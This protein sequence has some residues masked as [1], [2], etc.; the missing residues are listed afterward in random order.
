MATITLPNA[1][2]V[3]LKTMLRDKVSTL[4]L[5]AV[6]DPTRDTPLASVDEARKAELLAL[7]AR[8]N[9]DVASLQGASVADD[10]ADVREI[11]S[12]IPP[13]AAP[14]MDAAQA[15]VDEALKLW[16]DMDVDG[17][18]AK[19][20]DIATRAHT[21]Q[22]V[23]VQVPVALTGNV[24]PV[25]R[26]AKPAVTQAKRVG[27]I[28]ARDIL[29]SKCPEELGGISMAT[30]DCATAPA[31]DP[32]YVWPKDSGAMIAKLFKRHQAV[33]LVG[34]A[35]TGKTTFAQQ[36]AAHTHR[37]YI[38]VSCHAQTDAPTLTGMQAP[39][40]GGGTEWRDGQLTA[41]I[42][43]AG[44]II[45]I[46]EPFTARP[47]VL[48]MLHALLDSRTLH[49]DE[50]G[51]VVPVADG[52]LFILADNTNGTGDVSGQYVACN[53]VSRAL[54]SRVAY[55]SQVD[56]LA[57]AAEARVIVKR[58]G[59]NDAVARLLTEYADATRVQA[60]KG[61]IPHG[62]GMREL[63]SWAESI[64]DGVPS[65]QAAQGAFLN[66]CPPEQAEHFRQL[67]LT[68]CSDQMVRDALT[69]KATNTRAATGFSVVDEEE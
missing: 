18:K 59:C 47:G 31:I 20:A 38:R 32:F 9:I 65:M 25:I 6:S 67:L 66:T 10:A 50:T 63:V 36:L 17:F 57:P 5:Q 37:P 62:I 49:I 54:L 19:L 26:S 29:G 46:D 22:I 53:Q 42:R 1:T 64:T 15:D 60:N 7:A 27:K 68:K 44:A 28:T 4:D 34:P 56:Y 58:T 30:W 51:E 52:V 16:R 45:L 61:E 21:P 35:G 3:L 48:T 23:E 11:A 69:G 33:M 8:H 24:A 55:T 39:A 13:E 41:A 40:M 2:R 12:T 43:T 14:L